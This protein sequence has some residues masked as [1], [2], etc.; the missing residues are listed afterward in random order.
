MKAT[1]LILVIFTESAFALTKEEIRNIVNNNQQAVQDVYNGKHAHKKLDKSKVENEVVSGKNNN[2]VI[3]AGSKDDKSKYQFILP[4]NEYVKNYKPYMGKKY[5][6]FIVGDT[7]VSPQGNKNGCAFNYLKLVDDT[8]FEHRTGWG[9]YYIESG[10]G[11]GCARLIS[12]HGQDISTITL[13]VK[14]GGL[15]RAPQDANK[16]IPIFDVIGVE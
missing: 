6:V 7:I 8:G 9:Q 11:I 5:S 14:F 2:K 13:I 3:E 16:I 10:K 4:A 1:I 15:V 12:I